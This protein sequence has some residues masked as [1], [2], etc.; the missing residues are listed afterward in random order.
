MNEEVKLCFRCPCSEHKSV[1]CRA[2]DCDGRSARG[3]LRRATSSDGRKK[4]QN[5]RVLLA[6]KDY[7]KQKTELNGIRLGEYF[8]Q[9]EH[10]ENG[11]YG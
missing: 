3:V 10:R 8:S 5:N 11:S 2:K 4:K 6:D 7:I 1:F 9:T